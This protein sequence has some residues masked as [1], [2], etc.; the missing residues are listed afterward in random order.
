MKKI[1]IAKL[2]DWSDKVN[3]MALPI[4]FAEYLRFQTGAYIQDVFPHLN[5]TE[6]DFLLHGT[7]AEEQDE[8]YGTEERN[9]FQGSEDFLN[10]H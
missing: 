2:S 1:T 9:E 3:H 6:I 7:S 10:E 4:T 5:A 8:I